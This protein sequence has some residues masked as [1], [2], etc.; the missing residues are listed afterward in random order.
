MLHNRDFSGIPGAGTGSG[1]GRV[2]GETRVSK[3]VLAKWRSAQMV[4]SRTLRA[5]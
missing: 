3:C 5:M 1:T 2:G 4:A